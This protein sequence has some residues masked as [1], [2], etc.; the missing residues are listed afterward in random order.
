[1]SKDS[2]VFA[3]LSNSCMRL[4][5]FREIKGAICKKI[6]NDFVK[7]DLKIEVMNII[8]SYFMA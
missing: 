1:M 3:C 5:T 6:F 2:P 8:M 4:F 7:T